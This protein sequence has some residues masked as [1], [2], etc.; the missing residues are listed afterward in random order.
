MWRRSSVLIIILLIFSLAV[1]AAFLQFSSAIRFFC[2]WRLLCNG[3]IPFLT[4]TESFF[5]ILTGQHFSFIIETVWEKFQIQ[6]SIVETHCRILHPLW[7]WSSSVSSLMQ[8]LSKEKISRTSTS[9][10]TAASHHSLF[11][12]V[13]FIVYQV[14]SRY[15]WRTSLFFRFFLV[16]CWMR[17]H[18]KSTNGFRNMTTIVCRRIT[19]LWLTVRLATMN[20]PLVVHPPEWAGDF[21][22]THNFFFFFF[23]YS[24]I[25]WWTPLL[26]PAVTGASPLWLTT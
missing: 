9:G 8:N 6:D 22:V 2:I 20:Y 18:V 26:C 17:E 25:P 3:N 23:T 13:A 5:D 16:L 10:F 21:T 7:I 15:F 11:T 1:D 24:Y 4:E 19:V 12:G 14:S